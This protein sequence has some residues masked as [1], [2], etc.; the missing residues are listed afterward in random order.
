MADSKALVKIKDGVPGAVVCPMLT[1]SNYTVWAMR[2]KV[3]LRVHKVWETIE[4]GTE[5]DEKNDVATVL[6]FQ[7]IPEGL[8][9]QVG[10][11]GSPKVI[12]EAI[13]TRNLGAERVKSA[14]LQTLMNEFDR[15]KMEDSDSI[16][17]FSGK[18]SELAS[19]A[20]SLGQSIEGP[21]VV[22][23]FLNSL[24]PKFIHMTASLEQLLD[25]E[26]TSFE[27]IIE[28]LKA[29]EERIKGYEPFEQQGSLLYSNSEKSYDQRGSDNGGRGRGQNRGRGRGN[30]DRGRG[31]SN[32]NEKSKEKKDYSHIVCYN[33]KKKGHFASVCTEKKDEEELNKAE[34]KVADEALYMHEVV[35]LNE[36]KVMPKRLESDTKEDG[37]W[38][39]DNGA[40]NHMTGERCY[41]SEMN[42]NI[43][44]KVKFGDGSFVDISGK[45]SILFEA[46]TGEHKL[47]TDIYYI[48][49][50]RSNI[51]SLGQATEQGCDVRMKDNY[52]TLKDPEG[53]LLVKVMRTA[54]RLYKL[55][56]QVLRATCLHTRL[57]EEPW[58]W[59]ARLGHVNFKTIRAMATQGMVYV[60][61]R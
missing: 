32:T 25:L 18:I 57:E 10:D 3:L 31:R 11:L 51:L 21:K 47:L 53:R 38:Y 24:P 23:K 49:E 33:C 30:R 60:C 58:R 12:W 39:L 20:A 28:R 29:Y 27:D 4:L 50:L 17:T 55:K 42:E 14:R 59:H 44:G 43:K 40:S 19:K 26:T 22:K 56:L 7:S 8:I 34:T 9:L 1:T 61:R 6:L 36:G 48:P 45:G 52:L 5:D 41:F 2:M 54:N 46:K 16:D 15:M 35:F 37:V 13:K